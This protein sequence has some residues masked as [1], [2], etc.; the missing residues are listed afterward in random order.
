M[1][2]WSFV[3]RIK[4]SGGRQFSAVYKKFGKERASN[5]YSIPTSKIAYEF[6][7]KV[8]SLLELDIKHIEES[9]TSFDLIKKN[10]IIKNNTIK[11]NNK[12]M[13][14]NVIVGNPPYQDQG[15]SGGN[16]DAPIFQHFSSIATDL[17]SN[18]VSLIIPSR[19]FAAGREPLLGEFRRKMLNNG[20]IEKLEVFTNS[21]SLFPDVEIKGGVCIYLENK[22][23]QSNQCS[24]VLNQGGQIQKSTIILNAFDILIREPILAGIVSKVETIRKSLN[25]KTV[26]TIISYDT[27]FGIPSNPKESK[28]TPF[29]VYNNSTSSHDVLLFHIEKLVRKVEYVKRSDIK[30]NVDAIDKFKVFITGA[31][32]SGN[33]SK[34]MGRPEFAPKNSVC[35]QSYLF[36]AFKTKNEA[37]KFY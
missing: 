4:F 10:K 18:Y 24:Y 21:S 35:S 25:L 28:K 1:V 31:G 34:V 23:H 19:W 16:N 30:K 20:L 2:K 7:R 11:I 26:D 37:Q 36:S 27:P 12:N 14:F 29:R 32:G 22:N 13:K 5:F 8:Y 9:Y 33:D 6:T 17:S 3:L 15:G